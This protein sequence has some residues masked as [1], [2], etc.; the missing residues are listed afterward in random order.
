MGLILKHKDFNNGVVLENVY[1]KVDAV[2]GDKEKIAYSIKY[3]A[4][5]DA[6]EKELHHLCIESKSFISDISDVAPNIFKQCYADLKTNDP[7]FADAI[8]C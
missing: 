2:S 8:D 5:T 3:Y 4:S 7:E 1:C 6:R